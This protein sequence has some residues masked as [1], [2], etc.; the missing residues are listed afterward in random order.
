M[1]RGRVSIGKGAAGDGQELTR[2]TSRQIE[3][4]SK[5]CRFLERENGHAIYEEK[6]SI[7]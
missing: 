1:D 7:M 3:I 6:A 2:L 4:S 5:V